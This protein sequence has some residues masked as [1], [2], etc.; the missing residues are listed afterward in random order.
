VKLEFSG[1]RTPQ[2]NGKVEREFQTFFGRIRAMSNS[3][4]RKDHL[5]SGVWSEC[6]MTVNFLSNITAIKNKMIRHFQLLYESK[7][8][9]PESLRCFVEIDVVTTKND[10]QRKLTRRGTP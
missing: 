5:R 6:A 4:G 2:R 1:P 9:L 3:A 10:I 7:L 8:K